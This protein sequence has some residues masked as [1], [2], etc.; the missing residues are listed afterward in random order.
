M[1]M[2]KTRKELLCYVAAHHYCPL[3]RLYYISHCR[4]SSAQSCIQ[5]CAFHCVALHR[6]KRPRRGENGKA[7]KQQQLLLAAAPTAAISSR[8]RSCQRGS[9]QQQRQAARRQLMLM[10]VALL[11]L[12][13]PLVQLGLLQAVRL[14]RARRRVSQQDLQEP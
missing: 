6:R 5:P 3:V 2:L 8:V 9:E 10:L 12:L 13:L 1:L 11:L 4:K 7:G 14:P